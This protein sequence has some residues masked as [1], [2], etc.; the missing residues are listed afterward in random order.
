[1]F[2]SLWSTSSQSVSSAAT[3]TNLSPPTQEFNPQKHSRPQLQQLLHR[4]IEAAADQILTPVFV[5]PISS[6]SHPQSPGT[7]N[8]ITGSRTQQHDGD[9]FHRR[10]GAANHHINGDGSGETQ[11]TNTI[12]NIPQQQ[13][14]QLQVSSSAL[15]SYSDTITNNNS[16]SGNF[17][18]SDVLLV[19]NN[20]GAVPRSSIVSRG[21]GGSG[22]GATKALVPDPKLIHSYVYIIPHLICQSVHK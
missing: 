19:D 11:T 4:D 17:L 9:P 14:Q 3:K 5:Q 16:R 1:M 6:H 15:T 22:G 2:P 7:G 18:I 21:G 13:L 20:S 12:P 10:S 8:S